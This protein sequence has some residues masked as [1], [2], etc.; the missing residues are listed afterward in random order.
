MVEAKGISI[1]SLLLAAHNPSP[2]P[3]CRRYAAKLCDCDA[4]TLQLQVRPGMWRFAPERIDTRHASCAGPCPPILIGFS[5][6]NRS[7]FEI[8]VPEIPF[9]KFSNPADTQVE[10]SKSRSRTPEHLHGHRVPC[11]TATIPA[12]RR[13]SPA[14]RGPGLHVQRSAQLSQQ[15]AVRLINELAET[16]K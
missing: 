7:L 1:G 9:L 2:V 14:V 8:S 5:L 13:G 4:A 10:S 6:G 3:T 15:E 11:P 12:T 16:I